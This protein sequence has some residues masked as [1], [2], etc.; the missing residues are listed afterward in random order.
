MSFA[1]IGAIKRKVKG[2]QDDDGK[3]KEQDKIPVTTL[4]KDTT[5]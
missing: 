2:L 1:D 3:S 5:R 4:S